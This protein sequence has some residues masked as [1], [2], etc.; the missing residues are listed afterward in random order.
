[1]HSRLS[2]PDCDKVAVQIALLSG[3]KEDLF[4]NKKWFLNTFFTRHP[5]GWVYDE[6]NSKLLGPDGALDRYKTFEQQLEF[7]GQSFTVLQYVKV[8]E[9]SCVAANALREV[10]KR[11]EA[12][13]ARYREV[14]PEDL[15]ARSENLILNSLRWRNAFDAA[16]QEEA[17]NELQTL[18]DASRWP[19]A[20]R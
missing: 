18:T 6:A 3:D 17:R 20:S 5:R 12:I 19:N 2:I 8:E 9:G 15:Q 13:N 16:Q 11:A 4:V 7:V 14:A 1:M 10:S